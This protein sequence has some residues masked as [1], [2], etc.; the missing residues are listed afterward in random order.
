MTKSVYFALIAGF[1]VVL[2][3]CANEGPPPAGRADQV[4]PQDYP[5]IVPQGGL[6]RVLRFGRPI[7]DGAEPGRPM[8]VSVPVRNL[9][10]RELNVQYRFEYLDRA[11]RPLRTNTGWAYKTLT[12]RGVETTLESNSQSDEA[13]DWRLEIRPAR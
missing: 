8:L 2:T 1:L 3:G 12:G 13:A 4:S 11:G 6:A 5:Q 10:R 9:D 7:V